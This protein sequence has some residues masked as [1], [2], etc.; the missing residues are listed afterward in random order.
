VLV[1]CGELDLNHVVAEET[2]ALAGG[3]KKREPDDHEICIV[4]G[5]SH[6]LK[7]VKSRFE[8]GFEGDLVPAAAA[9]LRSWLGNHF[10]HASVQVD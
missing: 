2:A 3:L 1:I 4:P 9:K 7:P 6:N 8:L 10:R 5:A